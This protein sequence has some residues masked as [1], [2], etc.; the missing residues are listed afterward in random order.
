MVIFAGML[1]CYKRVLLADVVNSNYLCACASLYPVY[2]MELLNFLW[3]I[4]FLFV[5]PTF[6]ALTTCK[7]ITVM[8]VSKL[9]NK[10]KETKNEEALFSFPSQSTFQF[11]P[12][13][14]F[15]FDSDI[16]PQP[17]VSLG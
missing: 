2:L 17:V 14:Q 12:I 4:V 1:L 13:S 15:S 8:F 10:K 3:T 16:A 11:L 6:S 5:L 7:L 9:S